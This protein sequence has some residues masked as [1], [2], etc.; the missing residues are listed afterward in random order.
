[1][2]ALPLEALSRKSPVTW[3]VRAPRAEGKH[4]LKVESSTGAAQRQTI[5]IKARGLF[6]DN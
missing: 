4:T 5:T 1:M 2:P 6:G 3:R